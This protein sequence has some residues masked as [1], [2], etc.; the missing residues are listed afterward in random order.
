MAP[1]PCSGYS[2]ASL[3]PSSLLWPSFCFSTPAPESCGLISTQNPTWTPSIS[4]LPYL[5]EIQRKSTFSRVFRFF[6]DF[7]RGEEQRRDH[8]SHD[9]PS[10][11]SPC[12]TSGSTSCPCPLQ[13]NTGPGLYDFLL[14]TCIPNISNAPTPHIKYNF[15]CKK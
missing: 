3:L 5:Q 6:N 8:L 14:P 13:L 9:Q 10:A 11:V 1:H 12:T 15:C 2:F 7:L 4:L